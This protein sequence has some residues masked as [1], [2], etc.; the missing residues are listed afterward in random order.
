MLISPCSGAAFPGGHLQRRLY[1]HRPGKGASIA[2]KA[3]G[4][5]VVEDG[6]APTCHRLPPGWIPPPLKCGIT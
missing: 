5:L 6:K 1:H 4:R 2:T 3:L